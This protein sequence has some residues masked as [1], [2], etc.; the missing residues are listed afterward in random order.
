MLFLPVNPTFLRKS[1]MSVFAPAVIVQ[2]AS[3]VSSIGFTEVPEFFLSPQEQEEFIASENP[4]ISVVDPNIPLNMPVENMPAE[5]T[6]I[7]ED[8][9]NEDVVVNARE[10]SAQEASRQETSVQGTTLQEEQS[11]AELNSNQRTEDQRSQK[12]MQDT[13]DPS[14]D[15][16]ASEPAIP[17]EAALTFYAAEC[18]DFPVM[19]EY[20][21]GLTFEEAVKACRDLPDG[22]QNGGK[23]IGFSLH[24]GSE[25]EGDFP[26]IVSGQ[27]QEK[28]INSIGYFRD[29][30][31]VQNAITEAKSYFSDPVSSLAQG[32]EK[33]PSVREGAREGRKESVLA[34]LRENRE[35]VR[36]AEKDKPEKTNVT[37]RKKG[38][39]SL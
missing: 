15:P 35:K 14:P 17:V 21:G 23:G 25:F 11:A 4:D 34:A 18:I 27:V 9:V 5:N 31:A 7:N 10:A 1:L 8:V 38:E 12:T 29:S 26:L 33:P 6:V 20:H 28:V 13:R 24:D 16:S 39:L 37:Q 32:Q 36:A 19:G 30:P 22:Q 2:V 3:S